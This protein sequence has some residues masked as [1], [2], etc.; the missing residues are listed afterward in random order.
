MRYTAEI[1]VRNNSF[2]KVEVDARDA[3]QAKALLAQQ[4]GVREQDLVN[5]Y[6]RQPNYPGL[7]RKPNY[8]SPAYT[9]PP[10]RLLGDDIVGRTRAPVVKT[11]KH[12]SILPFLAGAATG[13][14]AAR[15][16]ESDDVVVVK[17]S[18]YPS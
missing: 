3:G 5:F 15:A 13:Y 7:E 17:E 11:E 12:S 4:Y 6:F 10:P 2:A 14:L 8:E 16:T 1:K 9:P 18:T